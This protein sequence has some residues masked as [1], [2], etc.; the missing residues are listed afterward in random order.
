MSTSLKS[1]A[2]QSARIILIDEDLLTRTAVTL[3]SAERLGKVTELPRGDARLAQL[4][5]LLGDMAIEP[6][7]LPQLEMRTIVHLQ[8]ADGSKRVMTG[9]KT[10]D[11]VM[12]LS[13][14]GQMASTHAP[15]RKSLE[16][17]VH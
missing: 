2:A 5:A 15:L 4:T 11:G 6:A 13:I 9:S 7:R 10:D 1:C 3:E 12:H 8:C 17:L 14:D 16:A